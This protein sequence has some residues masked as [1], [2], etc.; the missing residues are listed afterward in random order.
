MEEAGNNS[1]ARNRKSTPLARNNMTDSCRAANVHLHKAVGVP[2]IDRDTGTLERRV[3]PR[4][5]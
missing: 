5:M 1:A 4:A 2:G 3:L